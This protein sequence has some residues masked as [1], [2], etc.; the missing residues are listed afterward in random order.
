[1]GNFI[2][3]TVGARG[4]VQVSVDNETF[5]LKDIDDPLGFFSAKRKEY[6][7]R[8]LAPD[9]PIYNYIA[10]DTT[11]NCNLRCKF[12]CDD[13]TKVTNFRM[14]RENFLKLV[15]LAEIVPNGMFFLSCLFEP[16]LNARFH[17]FLTLIPKIGK[18]KCFFTTNLTVKKFS[19]NVFENLSTANLHYIN[20]SVDSL[21]PKT[22]EYLRVNAKFEVFWENLQNL[23]RVFASAADPPRLRFISIA[24]KSNY[25]EL[26]GLV[27]RSHEEFGVAQH[28]VRMA[29]EGT[30]EE[31]AERERVT[32][33]EWQKLEEQLA[34]SS[35]P[36]KIMPDGH[37]A[38][39]YGPTVADLFT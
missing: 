38:R 10:A 33:P 39:Y 14:T 16:F 2:G 9:F 36:V 20:I 26:L 24:F 3:L 18:S 32:A 31:W 29:F 11:D 15:S 12:C 6:T 34:L 17:E 21:I 22:F 35:F 7:E 23:T 37:T 1:M 8:S 28:E 13:W 30:P 5:F 4:N 19:A 25:D 27:R